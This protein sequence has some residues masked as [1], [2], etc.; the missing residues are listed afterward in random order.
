MARIAPT[1]PGTRAP[2]PDERA[3]TAAP[4]APRPRPAPRPAEQRRRHGPPRPVLVLVLLLVL[5]AVGWWA[6][7]TRPWVQ[8]SGPLTASGTLEADEILVGSEVAGRILELVAEGQSIRAGD[9]VARLDDSLVQLQIRQVDTAAQQQLLIQLERYRLRSPISGVVTRVPMHAGEV[10]SPGQAVVAVADLTSLELTAY[11]LE[12]DL[13]GVRVGQSVI[14]TADPF[15][16]R[17]FRGVVTSTNPRAEF[18]P[19]N[20]QTQRDRLNLVFGVKIRVENPDG[21]LKPGM[22]ADAIFASLS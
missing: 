21:V 7:T 2:A 10:V 9:V 3:P 22:P 15:P 11:V 16:E 8:P 1:K 17:A 14:V 6:A 4:P 18:T 5:G 20:V 12:R 13:G 19:R